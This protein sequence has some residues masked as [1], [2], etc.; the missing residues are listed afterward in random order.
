MTIH[1]KALQ[2]K[3]EAQK[4]ESFLDFGSNFNPTGNKKDLVNTKSFLFD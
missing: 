4:D 2:L 1:E 3:K